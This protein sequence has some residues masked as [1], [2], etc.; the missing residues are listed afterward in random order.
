MSVPP[1]S[2]PREPRRQRVGELPAM[3]P[4][5]YG[6][7]QGALNFLALPLYVF[8][9]AY[10]A[11]TASMPLASIGALLFA[12]RVL[13]A[14]TD[15]AL[16]RLADRA[17]RAGR[18]FGLIVAASVPMLGGFVL[19]MG[20]PQLLH[21]PRHP[22]AFD[23]L[24]G[25]ALALTYAGF[26]AASITH[27]AWGTMLAAHDSARARLFARREALGLLGVLLAAVVTQLG[28]ARGDVLVFAA[29]LA[30]ALWLLRRV[31]R[32]SAALAQPVRP[33]ARRAA[34]APLR[35]PAFRRLLAIGV[36]NGVAASLPATLV[37]FFIRDRIG[38]PGAAGLFLFL[39]FSCAALAAP[40]WARA[41]RR[42]GAAPAWLGGMLATAAVFVAAAAL[43]AGDSGRYALVC[44]ASGAMLGADL[45][46]PPTLLAGLIGRLGHA[47]QLEG[48]YFGLWNLAAKLTLALAAGIA[49]PAL[50]WLG[51]TPGTPSR[52]PLPAL[53]LAYCVLPSALKLIAAAMLW[54]GWM[55]PDSDPHAFDTTHRR[56]AQ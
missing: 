40:L 48:A 29:C 8:L 44:A 35:Q 5:R 17:L 18:G 9:P 55:R 46:L 45:V 41:V 10:V 51:Y 2:L 1:Q 13:D 42:V 14:L 28:G 53:V 34:L 47:R 32:G 49:L 37:L 23:A 36:V 3:L 31:P 21:E 25:A 54:L 38:A 52:G 19:L 56:Q 4:T 26:S 43:H 6:A 22:L 33:G 27:Q 30:A 20:L 39:Y 7:L 11:R 15:P 50:A 16:G 12:S 24:L